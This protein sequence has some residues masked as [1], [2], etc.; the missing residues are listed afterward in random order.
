MSTHRYFGAMGTL[1][2]F[3]LSPSAPYAQSPA[4][5]LPSAKSLACAFPLYAIGTWKNGEPAAEVKSTTLGLRFDAIEVQEGSARVTSTGLRLVVP[6]EIIV[7]LSGGNL[8]F[9]HTSNA[10]TLYTTTVFNTE[11]RAGKLM[12]VHTRHEYTPV[13]V[14]GYTSR[15]EQYYGECEIVK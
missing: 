4:E 10:G 2:F 6:N 8:H 11:S 1:I 12:A 5:A 14:P 15:P 9:I 7:Q 13:S 3:L